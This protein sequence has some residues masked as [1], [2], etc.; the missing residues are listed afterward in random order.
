MQAKFFDSKFLLFYHMKQ[1]WKRKSEWATLV[2]VRTISDSGCSG[3]PLWTAPLSPLPEHHVHFLNIYTLAPPL[4]WSLS[5]Y[6]FAYPRK[7]SHSL[8]YCAP[9]KSLI[10]LLL[11][12]HISASLNKTGLSLRQSKIIFLALYFRVIKWCPDFFCLSITLK[13]S[14]CFIHLFL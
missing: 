13:A 10:L 2:R 12:V 8:P 14:F 4:L 9:D 6:P 11:F 5:W 3:C 1:I 7:W